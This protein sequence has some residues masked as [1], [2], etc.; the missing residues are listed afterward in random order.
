[1]RLSE[2]NLK[3]LK[4]LVVV[5]F[6]LYVL[7]GGFYNRLVKPT[8]FAY[9]RGEYYTI[10]PE[11]DKQTT[12]ESTLAFI[13]N[14]TT[15]LGIFTMASSGWKQRDRLTS[16]RLMIIGIGLVIAGMIGSYTLIELKRI[17]WYR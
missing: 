14:L 10:S 3:N 6:C 16:N 13:C 4:A 15:F 8:Q 11:M 7:S 5:I 17:P 12:G 9:W 2:D 1:M